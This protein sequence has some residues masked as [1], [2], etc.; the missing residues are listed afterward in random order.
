MKVRTDMV[1]D[2]RD[3]RVFFELAKAVFITQCEVSVSLMQRHLRIGYQHALNIMAQL[4][5]AGIVTELNADNARTLTAEYVRMDNV[6][7]EPQ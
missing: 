6:A 7:R 4:E 1:F 2:D 5:Q 3:D